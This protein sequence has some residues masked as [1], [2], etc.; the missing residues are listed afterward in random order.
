VSKVRL[1]NYVLQRVEVV[2]A[3]IFVASVLLALA[4]TGAAL[5][6]DPTVRINAADQAKAESSLARLTDFGAGWTG[7]PK[8]PS[9]LTAPNCPGFNPKESD[10]VV[11]G[12]AEA[13]F[14]AS[15]VG[16]VFGQDSQVLESAEAVKTDFAR[17]VTPKLPGC[18]AYQL[19][20]GG[21]GNVLSVSIRKLPLPRIG[22][23][24]AAYRATVL[25]K[26]QNRTVKYVSDDIFFGQGR[27]EFA[28]FVQ[29][30]AALGSQVAS[31][32]TA[33]ARILVKRAPTG[34][35]A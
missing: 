35:V 21:K 3:R 15:R 4:C 28:L 27:F 24:S 13:R 6:D 14:T 33:M 34:N 19:K 18:L 1:K 17:T 30:P 32:E 5:A 2:A 7:G 9:K 11:T 29:A 26:I 25:L 10:L 20:A 12:H 8:T 22:T 16:V 23:V 31:F